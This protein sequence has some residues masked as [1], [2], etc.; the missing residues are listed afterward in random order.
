MSALATNPADLPFA[1][2]Y[3]REPGAEE[4]QL[5][6]WFGL[7]AGEPTAPARLAVAATRD[8]S[9][10]L[11]DAWQRGE[12]VLVAS[13]DEY[14]GPLPAGDWPVPPQQALLLPLALGSPLLESAILVVGL[15]ARR[16]LDEAYR[17]FLGLVADHAGR[18][19]ARARAMDEAQRLNQAL[20]EMNTSLDSFVHIVAHDLKG[21]ITNLRGLVGA[22]AEELPGPAREQVVALVG[23]EVE[24]LSETVQ[25]LLQV[26]QAQYGAPTAEAATVDW[27]ELY[28]QIQKEL[29][30]YVHQQQ[31][32]LVSD[33]AAAPTVRYPRAYAASILKNLVH[34][35]LKYRSA[36]RQ[37]VV[38]VHTRREGSTV[39]LTVADNGR[40]IDLPRDH[41]RLF[42]PFTRLTA[43]GEGAGLGL[44][45]VRTLVEQRGGTLTVSSSLSVGTTFT[46]RLPETQPQ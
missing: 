39:V 32:T 42:Q 1:L 11:A 37:P 12:P 15:S 14:V 44:H 5:R 24:R 30:E 25:G 17:A 6:A 16:P 33:F 28:A 34:N 3:T 46:V 29:A 4:A 10:P 8:R 45:L 18:A 31:G 20:R 41:E 13:L 2:L 7:P 21:P 22:Y 40:G 35:A 27:A 36:E 19:L 23:H 9:W 26:L 43:E 38:H